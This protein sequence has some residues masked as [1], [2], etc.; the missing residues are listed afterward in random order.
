MRCGRRYCTWKRKDVYLD[1]TFL[2]IRPPPLLLSD[3]TKNDRSCHAR[4]NRFD[5]S[6]QR[7]AK[8]RRYAVELPPLGMQVSDTR[9]REKT[10]VDSPIVPSFSVHFFSP[11]TI[12][13]IMQ[14][15]DGTITRSRTKIFSTTRTRY[16]K[17]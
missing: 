4:I 16:A 9:V 14:R 11:R 3:G 2:C 10:C 7:G 6:S 5:V 17:I 1:E 13:I 8:S 12:I 15:R